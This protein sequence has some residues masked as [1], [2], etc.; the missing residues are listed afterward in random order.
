MNGLKSKK[1]D[2]TS[3]F[4]IF[5]ILSF[6]NLIAVQVNHVDDTDETYGYW[7]P[8]H[9]LLFGVGMQTWEYAPEFAIRTYSFVFPF[10]IAGFLFSFAC[11]SKLALFYAIRTFLG[12]CNAFVA[13][14]FIGSIELAFGSRLSHLTFCFFLT[15]PG[16]FYTSTS[17][18]PSAFTMTITMITFTAWLKERFVTSIFFG[19][20]AVLWSGWPFVGVLLVPLGIHMLV[21]TFAEAGVSAVARLTFLGLITLLGVGL[22]PILIDSWFYG[23][24]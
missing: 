3:F 4:A 9:Y 24:M 15:S 19:C 11:P 18:L 23:R 22:P 8:L 1:S 6:V 14:K 2:S 10:W 5:L 7:E 13:S 17:L 21:T 16:M 20:I 12:I